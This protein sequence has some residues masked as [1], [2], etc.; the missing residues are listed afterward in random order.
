MNKSKTTQTEI[1]N[2]EARRNEIIFCEFRQL[3]CRCENDWSDR[4]FRKPRLITPYK[5]RQITELLKTPHM[6]VTVDEIENGLVISSGYWRLAIPNN[7]KEEFTLSLRFQRTTTFGKYS[8]TVNENIFA[9][10]NVRK[11]VTTYYGKEAY[12]EFRRKAMSTFEESLKQI[13]RKLQ[14][15]RPQLRRK[16]LTCSE[17]SERLM[18][19]VPG[20]KIDDH[21][22]VIEFQGTE[23]Q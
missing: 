13:M 8:V 16:S 4:M 11:Y 1:N 23:L 15:L 14:K 3:A 21:Y 5:K 19:K 9:P 22:A 7:P 12:Q 10:E 2:L 6:E 17:A 18:A 20:V